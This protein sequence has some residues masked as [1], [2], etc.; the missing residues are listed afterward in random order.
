MPLTTA[1]GVELHYRGTADGP[2]PVWVMGTGY[3]GIDEA[4]LT[5]SLLGQ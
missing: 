3:P 4:P 5:C 2:P 1:N